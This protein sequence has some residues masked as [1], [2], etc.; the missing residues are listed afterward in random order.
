MFAGRKQHY[1][2]AL[3]DY[4]RGAL[5]G[6]CRLGLARAA[7]VVGD[8][9]EAKRFYE[10]VAQQPANPLAPEASLR[11]GTLLYRQRE[12]PAAIEQLRPS[13]CRS[14]L[15]RSARLR[16]TGWGG[17]SRIKTTRNPRL[18]FGNEDL[19]RTPRIRSRRR[20]R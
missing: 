16:G 10:F 17:R 8:V 2:Q 20:L 7:E 9:A 19:P 14:L 5:V 15:L 13:P 3:R 18:R 4:P 11:L 6:E 1:E 12:L